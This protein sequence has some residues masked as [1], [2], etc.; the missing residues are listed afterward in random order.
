[1]E[2]HLSRPASHR[3]GTSRPCAAFCGEKRYWAG[4]CPRS[5]EAVEGYF[6]PII[7]EPLYYAA[8]AKLG[9]A[10]KI[11]ARLCSCSNLFT[12][13]VFCRRCGAAMTTAGAYRA[14][15]SKLICQSARA[16][17]SGCRFAGIPVATL[18]KTVL[19]VLSD[20]VVAALFAS[21]PKPSR[22]DELSGKLQAVKEQIERA[23]KVFWSSEVP[24]AIADKL[25]KLQGEQ[26]TLASET[27]AEK[28]K[29]AVPGLAEWQHWIRG[30]SAYSEKLK[31]KTAR[32]E[33]RRALA[34]VLERVEVD[35]AHTGDTWQVKLTVKG[36]EWARL[37]VSR[38]GQWR[39]AELSQPVLK[40]KTA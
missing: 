22:V 25:A 32:P 24:Q 12:G 30:C 35:P 40:A 7:D 2:P 5:G 31:D 13:L 21:E 6:P 26:K 3:S 20:N 33:L 11:K 37:K 27:E 17:R 1:M 10:K 16:G 4:Y 36:G 23:A 39:Y 8:Q 34:G 9:I 29:A 38:N 15:T 14:S 18:E 19:D 28:G